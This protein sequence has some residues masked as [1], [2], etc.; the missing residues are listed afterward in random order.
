MLRHKAIGSHIAVSQRQH[1]RPVCQDDIGSS[2]SQSNPANT[3]SPTQ[4]LSDF[5]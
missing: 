2:Q 5:S 4:L 3:C 1:M